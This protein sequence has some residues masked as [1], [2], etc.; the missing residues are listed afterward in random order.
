MSRLGRAQPQRQ[1]LTFN[2]P[3]VTAVLT[4]TIIAGGVSES[5]IV[6]GGE[7]LIVTLT[8][9]T[10]AA[11]GTGPIGSTA[12]SQAFIDGIT[13]AQAEAGGWNAKV[14]DVLVPATALVRTSNTVATLTV[15]A[16]ADY[17]ITADETIEQT[18]PAALLVTSASPIVATPIFVVRDEGGVS[19]LQMQSY[20]GMKTLMG[21]MQ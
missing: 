13:S 12:D 8:N 15:P 20:Q 9:D 21:N 4:G 3:F 10:W 11:A 6:T 16:T 2:A 7:T 1:I 5:E 17:V 18:I 19:L 14:R